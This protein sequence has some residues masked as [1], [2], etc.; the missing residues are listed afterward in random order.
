MWRS[1]HYDENTDTI[2]SYI[3][4]VKQVTALL[5]YGEPQ[6]L[7]LFKNTL[8]SRLYYMLYQIDD[9]RT[10]IETV[11]RVLTKEKIDNQRTRQSSTSPF[12]KA[13]QENSKKSCEK[14]VSFGA[15][16]T[17]ERNRDSIDKLTSLV[18]KLDM[19][20]DRRE[21]QYRPR[22]NQGRNRGCSQRQDSYRPRDRSYS[23][24]HGQYNI[25][26]GR[27]NYNNDRNNRA[28]SRSRNGYGRN[29][30]YDYRPNYRRD[31]FRQDQGD[32]RYR[33]RG[34]SHDRNRSRQRF[35]SNSRNINQYNSRDQSRSRDRRQR[36]R[37][38]SRD[39]EREIRPRTES[40]SRSSS[41][42]GTN[43]DRLRCY[44]CSEYDH[45]ERECPN[46]LTDESSDQEDSDSATLQM[47]TQDETLTLNYAEMEDLNM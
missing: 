47:L 28:R 3:G 14:G 24:D 15:L 5:N 25:N 30:R 11:K 8:P 10:A 31:N 29:D 43:R 18:N 44:R 7:E 35:R 4:R 38:I 39:R 23:R 19:K 41:H 27:Q 40:R 45:F 34:V 42:V 32:Q 21:T 16:E 22:I 33:N 17:I 36:S 13:S 46:A 2:D 12:M 20:L 1:F 6:I 26:R 9:L 37:T